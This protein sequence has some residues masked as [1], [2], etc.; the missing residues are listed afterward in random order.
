MPK[1]NKRRANK[2]RNM[3]TNILQYAEKGQ[4]QV[5]AKVISSLGGSPP[6][7]RIKVLNE[8]EKIATVS[9]NAAKTRISSDDWVLAEPLCQS[10]E[11]EKYII[12]L[13]YTKDQVK[14][15]KK[16]N[17]LQEYVTDNDMDN[18]GFQFGDGDD[19]NETMNIDDNIDDLLD[20]L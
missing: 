2:S 1:K 7:F 11:R 3:K 12:Q 16:E 15:L 5:Y 10:K 20:D 4:K 13:K 14:I 9:G 8:G 17:L 19:D 6:N 18:S